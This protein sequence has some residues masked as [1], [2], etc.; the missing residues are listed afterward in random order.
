MYL[1]DS[2]KNFSI[3]FNGLI[4][5]SFLILSSHNG[6][7]EVTFS[8]LADSPYSDIEFDYI[9]RNLKSI[10]KDSRFIIHVGDIFKHNASCSEESY[11]HLDQLLKESPIPVFI[12]PGDKETTRCNNY[13][14]GLNLW[15]KYFLN[16]ED[17]WKHGLTVTRQKKRPENFAFVLEEI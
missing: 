12:I 9:S 2:N 15:K 16:F 7:P 4:V 3:L 17:H 1:K 11:K 10:P 14:K 5:L 13:K 6:F 8:A